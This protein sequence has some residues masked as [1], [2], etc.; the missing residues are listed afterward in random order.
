MD[1][2]GQGKDK[3]FIMGLDGGTWDVL[4]PLMD[5]GLMPHLAGLAERG[6]SGILK[7]TI[8]PETASAWTTFQTGVNSGK[9]GI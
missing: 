5:E 4:K 9:H 2:P 3:V 1:Q 6:T 7:S 8:T